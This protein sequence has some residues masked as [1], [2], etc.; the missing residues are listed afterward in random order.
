MGL[1]IQVFTFNAFQE[2]TYVVYDEATL[3]AAVIDPGCHSST[4][5]SKLK[6][7]IETN[8]LK[9]KYL[10]NTHC[11]I[12]H[13]LGNWF[14]KNTYNVPLYIHQLDLPTLRSVPTQASMYGMAPYEPAE[15]DIFLEEGQRILLGTSGLDVLFVPGHAPGHVAF[16][17]AEQHF[18]IGGDVL[19]RE[20]VGRTDFPGCN[21]SHLIK[22]IKE[23]LFTLPDETIVMPGHGPNTTIGHEKIHNPYV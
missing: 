21:H 13:V 12:D 2:N 18:C 17:N 15:P 5:Q 16:Y 7:F 6:N 3:E 1:Q 20:S 23:K 11:H 22:S 4:E 10:L 9:V 19:F 8:L 14:V